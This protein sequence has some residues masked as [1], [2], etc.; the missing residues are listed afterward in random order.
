M[1]GVYPKKMC[2]MLEIA[3]RRLAKNLEPRVENWYP[4]TCCGVKNW[5]RL[6]NI[7]L[8]L[9]LYT[10]LITVLNMKRFREQGGIE[11]FSGI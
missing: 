7:Y 1:R 6:K 11:A 3:R 4:T 10:Y 9:I 8:C 5:Y 2:H